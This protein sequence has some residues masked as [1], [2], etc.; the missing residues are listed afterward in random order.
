M[1]RIPLL[2]FDSDRS[3]IINPP[4]HLQDINPPEHCVMPIYG[5]LIEK[6]WENGRLEKIHDIGGALCPMSVFVLEYD[7]RHV[8]VAHPGI[9]APF[10]AGTFEVLIAMGCRKF[11]ACGSAG[12]LEPELERGAIVIPS[13]AIRDE[14]TSYHYCPP[15]RAIDVD[16]SVV[17]NLESV[18]RRHHVRYEV[19]RTWT[20]DAIYRETKDKIA[21]RKQEGCL[22]VEMECSALVAVAKFRGVTFGQYLSAGDDVSGDEWD[23]RYC[24]DKAPFHEKVFWLSVE[25]CLSL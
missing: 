21:E 2:E 6:L 24:D 20:T 4:S 12:V 5:S 13:S 7:D 19:G 22:T 17:S 9:G 15:S 11:V 25:A 10:A 8:T 3:A 18:V 14:G 23:P 1:E 16:Q